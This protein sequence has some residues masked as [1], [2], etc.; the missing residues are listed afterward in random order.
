[1][2]DVTL[3]GHS[4]VTLRDGVRT[5]FLDPGSL[6]DLAA[7][8]E[9][10]AVLVT[11]QH[12]DH[13]D[14]AALVGGA[15]PVWAPR[16]VVDHLADAGVPAAR[17]HAA[18]PGDTLSAAGF[19][20]TVLGGRHAR[21]HPDVPVVANLAYLVEGRVLH[22]GDSFPEVP[23]PDAVEVLLLP[24]AA[25]WL[26]LGEAVD[27]ARGFPCA[28]VLPIHDAILSDAGR[29]FADALLTRLLGDRYRRPDP[30]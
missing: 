14:P 2:I 27:W 16:D 10:A 6:S 22:P 4:A 17:L 25:P 8:P 26:K 3:H 24:I 1:M 20:T 19:A 12:V 30:A 28:R 5:L 9:A 15:A 29:R 21:I 7:L 13:V 11:H 23:A 18:A